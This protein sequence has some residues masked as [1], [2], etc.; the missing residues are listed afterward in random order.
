MNPCSS[1]IECQSLPS[2]RLSSV[3]LHILP[4]WHIFMCRARW[5]VTPH[6][7]D[8]GSTVVEPGGQPWLG[9]AKALLWIVVSIGCGLLV[10]G[11]S[12]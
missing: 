8:S 2:E 10:A 5:L 1:A 7:S 4:Q 3:R 12:G 11:L 6:P 9:A